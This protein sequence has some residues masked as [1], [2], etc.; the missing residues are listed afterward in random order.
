[1][2]KNIPVVLADRTVPESKTDFATAN[3]F[4]AAYEITKYLIGKVHK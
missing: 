4:A 1:M 2:S 3:N